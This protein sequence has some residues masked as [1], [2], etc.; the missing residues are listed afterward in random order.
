MAA[1]MV[2][3]ISQVHAQQAKVYRIGALFPG[4]SASK[5]LATTGGKIA[6]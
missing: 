4:G 2:V 5:S 3:S 6:A 1:A